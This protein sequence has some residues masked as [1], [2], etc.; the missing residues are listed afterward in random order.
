VSE[1]PSLVK[2]CL[3]DGEKAIGEL[4][5]FVTF[6]E[7]SIALSPFTARAPDL[8]RDMTLRSGVQWGDGGLKRM[9]ENAEAVKRGL[10][11][12]AGLGNYLHGLA[13]VRLCTALETTADRLLL[14]M[15]SEK[16][17]WLR[18]PGVSSIKALRVDVVRLLNFSRHEQVE[19]LA[20]EIR[21]GVAASLKEGVGR[22]ESVLEAVG[23]SGPVPESVRSA[24]FELTEVRNVV[25]HRNAIADRRLKERCPRL[26]CEIGHAISIPRIDFAVVSSAAIAY[27]LE[28]WGRVIGIFPEIEFPHET[29]FRQKI[30]QD[31]DRY[32]EMRRRV[33][34]NIPPD[35]SLPSAFS[36]A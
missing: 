23:L 9:E 2:E 24:I 6:C 27:L 33:P 15:L 10:Q 20:R 14:A 5:T 8:A 36:G 3:V 11:D 18:Y 30:L 35:T 26:Q 1:L 17:A 13:Y 22:Y 12:E 4:F 25:V 34:D 28:I 31:L 19:Y 21:Q 32:A 7:A 16:E 29:D